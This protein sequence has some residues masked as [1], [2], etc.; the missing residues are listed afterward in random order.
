VHHDSTIAVV[1]TRAARFTVTAVE[2]AIR[3]VE[4]GD[5]R[6][7]GGYRGGV[8]KELH[9]LSNPDRY[10]KKESCFLCTM[11]T[12]QLDAYTLNRSRYAA[13]RQIGSFHM[14]RRY[15]GRRH[16]AVTGDMTAKR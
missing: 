8:W 16:G 7:D 3:V 1:E 5:E 15:D 10:A 11:P 14:P 2:E 13:R 4:F 12:T 9:D 6:S